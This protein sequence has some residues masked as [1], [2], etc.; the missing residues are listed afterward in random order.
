M[1]KAFYERDNVSSNLV[2]KQRPCRLCRACRRAAN[3]RALASCLMLGRPAQRFELLM[4]TSVCTSL[5]SPSQSTGRLQIACLLSRTDLPQSDRRGPG[6]GALNHVRPETQTANGFPRVPRAWPTAGT[7]PGRH[8][9]PCRC[10]LTCPPA[11]HARVPGGRRP[12]GFISPNK[13]RGIRAVSPIR[14]HRTRLV[15]STSYVT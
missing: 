12:G 10:R 1:P 5:R 7:G 9:G 14:V 8:A 15:P 13:N 2:R 6:R 4:P 3:C 11:P